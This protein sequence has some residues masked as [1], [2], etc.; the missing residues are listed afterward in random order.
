M[1]SV[2]AGWY[3]DPGAPQPGTLRWWDGSQWTGHVQQ[4]TGPGVQATGQA[5]YAG[6]GPTTDDGQQLAGWWQRV[7]AS[8]IDTVAG[9]ALALPATIPAQLGMQR[10]MLAQQEQ[11]QR[12][13]EAGEPIR[14]GDIWEPVRQMYAD[15]W[16][17]VVVVP[18]LLV[19]AYHVGFLRWRGATPGKMALGIKVRPRGV[20]GTLP[21]TSVLSRV[22]FQFLV[23][24]VLLVVAVLSGSTLGLVLGYL[25]LTAFFL[26]DVLW[27]A[28]A[29]RRALHDLVAGTVVVR[30]R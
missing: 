1:T 7:A 6:S 18:V 16:L 24:Q 14:F 25:A 23:G 2:P 27:A 10:D 15:Q 9:S 3:P 8:L 28:G 5:G 21:W 20:D 17:L 4:G 26:V 12:Q 19:V 22:G 13:V 29:R 11:M 30:T